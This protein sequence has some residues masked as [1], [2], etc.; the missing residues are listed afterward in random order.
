[1][2]QGKELKLPS[3]WCL[4]ITK[5]GRVVQGRELKLSSGWYMKNLRVGDLIQLVLEIQE[6]ATSI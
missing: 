2:V 4:I 3:S 1:V 6:V 5:G